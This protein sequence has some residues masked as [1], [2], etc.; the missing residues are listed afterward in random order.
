MH[1][2][3]DLFA[4][5]LVISAGLAYLNHRALKLPL[6]V[7]LLVGAVA[8]SLAL[9]ALDAVLP[10]L[11][12]KPAIRMLV[13]SI[14]FP[15]TLLNGFLAFLLFAGALHVDSADLFARKWTILALAT[16]GTVLSTGLVALALLAVSRLCGLGISLAWC[17]VFGA[18]ISPTDPVSVLDVLKRVGIPRTLQVTVAGESLFNDGVGVVLFTLLLALAAGDPIN[19]FSVSEIAGLFLLEAVGGG[20][21][22]LALGYLALRLI[23]RV[24]DYNV[25]LIISLALASGTYSLAGRLGISGPIAVVVAGILIGNHGIAPEMRGTTREHLMTF[26]RFVEETLNAL[27]FLLIGLEIAA[28]DLDARAII[29]MLAMIPLVLAIRWISVAASALPLHLRLPRRYASLLILTWGGLRGGLSI[30]M[31]LSLPAGP[32]TGT[33]LTIAYG[34]VVFS[35][36]VQG[37]SLEPVARRLLPNGTEE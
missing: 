17:L 15:N 4:L 29:A 34:I 1:S 14:D 18:L 27:L 3:S 12:I 24:D 21:L 22:G 8:G 36:V 9:I 26:W 28:I 2:T 23:R 5:L 19:H 25:E 16:F 35:I 13:A 10:G 11:A 32:N 31:A 37:L 6:T 33:I 20:L 7:G 30:A